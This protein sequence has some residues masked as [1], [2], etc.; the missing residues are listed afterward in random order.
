MNSTLVALERDELRS[1]EKCTEPLLSPVSVKTDK[2]A[3][4]CAD[5]R[6]QDPCSASFDS[7]QDVSDFRI[8][9][10]GWPVFG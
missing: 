4:G 7:R 10:T 1:T 5:H 3:A 8:K 2:L 6:W 9:I